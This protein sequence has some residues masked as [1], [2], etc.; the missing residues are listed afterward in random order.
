MTVEEMIQFRKLI[1]ENCELK[2]ELEWQKRQYTKLC[3]IE[4]IL[5]R[6]GDII[7]YY[8][9]DAIEIEPIRGDD[10]LAMSE[11]IEFPRHGVVYE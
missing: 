8:G 3:K 2:N 11:M 9:E 10:F 1:E 4:G 7:K 6:N 5:V